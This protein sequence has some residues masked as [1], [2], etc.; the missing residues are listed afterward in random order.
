MNRKTPFVV[1]EYYHIYNRGTDKRDIF[2]DSQD[3]ERFLRILYLCNTNKP[4]VVRDIPIGETYGF[5]REETIVDIGAYCLMKNHF[6]LLMREKIE[7]GIS[8]FMKKIS[9]AY[10]MYFNSKYKRSGRLTEGVF[11]AVHSAD[12]QQLQ[13]LFAYIHLNPLKFLDPQWH[14]RETLNT[15]E[16]K[17]YLTD[18]PHSSFLDWIG[19]QRPEN[20]I[21]TTSSFPWSFQKETEFVDH[22]SVWFYN[23][24][25][26]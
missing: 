21:I 1:D 13:Y 5:N 2:L 14:T 3:Y 19:R 17:Q 12:D 6:H 18:Y 8:L 10:S 25:K 20:E 26:G 7:G 15:T 9:T 16:I 24:N 22:L 11:K 23:T 4:I